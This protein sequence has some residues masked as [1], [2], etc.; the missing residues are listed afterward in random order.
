MKN[1]KRR[2]QPIAGLTGVA[3][4]LVYQNARVMV[5]RISDDFNE[6]QLILARQAAAQID[7]RL[8]VIALELGGVQKYLRVA[9]DAHL[10]FAVEEA[11]ERGGPAG[12]RAV[13]LVDSAG[14]HTRSWGTAEATTVLAGSGPQCVSPVATETRLGPLAVRTVDGHPVVESVLCS[15]V[16]GGA[17]LALIDVSHLISGITEGIRSGRTGYAWVIDDKGTFLAHSDQ[18][19]EAEEEELAQ[20]DQRNQLL[21]GQLT[22][23]A[24]DGNQPPGETPPQLAPFVAATQGMGDNV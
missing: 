3:L 2:L 17:L 21:Q 6:Q 7:G 1:G 19:D 13:A 14:W 12:M 11:L 4:Y 16:P 8:R 5:A 23:V 15:P 10:S 22:G 20:A 9:G 24:R 18:D